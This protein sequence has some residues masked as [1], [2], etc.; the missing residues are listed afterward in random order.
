MALAIARSSRI[1]RPH[2]GIEPQGDEP[3]GDPERAAQR[4]TRR[5]VEREV[6][7]KVAVGSLLPPGNTKLGVSVQ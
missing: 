2:C 5:D 3:A 1:R 4:G 7:A 6:H